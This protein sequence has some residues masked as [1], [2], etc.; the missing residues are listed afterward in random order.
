[1]ALCFLFS[2]LLLLLLLHLLLVFSEKVRA[3]QEIY[4]EAVRLQQLLD[5]L[6]E[7]A[8]S[9]FNIAK[10]A[11]AKADGIIAEALETL[12][13]LRNFDNEVSG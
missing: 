7:E 5:G 2:L 13:V 4:E 12:R 1:M 3:T 6:L 10:E 11:K 9:A 8:L